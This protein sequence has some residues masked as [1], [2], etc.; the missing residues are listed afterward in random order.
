MSSTSQIH[1][2]QCDKCGE[3][4][5]DDLNA[6][7]EW[8]KPCQA[9]YL[10]ENFANWTS[11]NENIDGLIQE[12]RSKIDGPS[13]IVFEWI[14]YNQFDNIREDVKGNS[15]KVYS[16]IWKD[17][18]LSYSYLKRKLTRVSG[19]KV[20]LKCVFNLQY[21][22]D[23]I[24]NEVK[25]YSVDCSNNILKIYGIS[26]NPD[27]KDYIMVLHNEY[28]KKYCKICCST[29]I[30]HKWC[31]SCHINLIRKN[32]IN[33]N[34]G[35]KEVDN[36]I[37]EMQLSVSNSCT[38]VFEWIPYDRFDNINKIGED[39]ICVVYSAIWKDGPLHYEYTTGWTR[40]PN[41][42]VALKCLQNA[43]NEFFLNEVKTYSINYYDDNIIYGISQNP[44]TK[45]YVM[46]IQD[47]YHEKCVKCEKTYIDMRYEWYNPCH[48]MQYEWYS[49][50]RNEKIDSFIQEMRTSNGSKNI[51]FNLIPYNH[52][53][54]VKE[55]GKGGFSTVHS[56]IWKDGPIYYFDDKKEW[57]RK[58]NKEVALKILYNSQ[59]T[60]NEILN[61][62]KAHLI[63]NSEFIINIYGI[64]QNPDTKDYI[65]V[66]DYA[67]G[68]SLN[69]YINKNLENFDWFNGLK[70]LTNIIEGLDKIHQKQMKCWDPNPDNRPN[71]FEIKES[72]YLFYHSLDQNFK[73]KEQR[74]YDIEERFKLFIHLVY[75]R[76][77]F[78]EKLEELSIPWNCIN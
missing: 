21:N 33:G 57:I 15:S 50:F 12:M 11:G 72:I 58:S 4:Y 78:Q 10:K 76:N 26:Q 64:S 3:H 14:P 46:I 49:H 48:H 60:T 2:G 40:E 32:F 37:Q 42:K 63:L 29:K 69:N 55:I 77:L 7:S 19:K 67:K 24:I 38:I 8:C 13:D 18:P 59:N 25:T 27:T 16:A 62:V 73:E 28:F 36:Y 71:T 31:N 20:A 74:H 54:N 65:M 1:W 23:E 56:A 75:F 34:S 22:I 51:N 45:V 70:I 44:R 68:G 61:E 6:E 53:S 17:G 47:K 30:E 9:K 66:L 5:G 43:T 35:N 39:N 52:F 41:K